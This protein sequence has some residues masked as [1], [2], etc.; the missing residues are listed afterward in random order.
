MKKFLTIASAFIFLFGAAGYYLAFTAADQDAKKEMAAL[1]QTSSRSRNAVQLSFSKEQMQHELR[2]TGT[3]E[4]IYEGKHY[5]V[6][7]IAEENG[8]IIFSCLSDDRETNLFSWFKNN[9]DHQNSN[10]ASGKTSFK[11]LT[12]DWFFEAE[13]FE[14]HSAVSETRS[15]ET[16][17]LPLQVQAEIPTPPPNA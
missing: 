14:F 7:S 3:K 4:F 11:P 17:I 12:L 9:L 6:I 13:H 5:D 2:F 15:S 10:S 8:K 16:N 1:T